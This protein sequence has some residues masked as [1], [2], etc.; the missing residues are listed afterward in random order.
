MKNKPFPNDLNFAVAP[1]Q[2][3]ASGKM[4]EQCY[5]AVLRSVYAEIY[6]LDFE[7]GHVRQEGGLADPA[8][9]DFRLPTI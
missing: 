5:S 4:E 3:L 6:F 8:D 1:M 9:S 2:C 7:Q